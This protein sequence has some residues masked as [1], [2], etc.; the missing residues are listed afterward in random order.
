MRSGFGTLLLLLLA[1]GVLALGIWAPTG[2]TG[3]D[4]YLLGLRIPLEMMERDAWWIPF[5][6]GEPRLKKPPFIYWLG[7]ASF[8]TFGPSLA[9]GRAVTV[10]FAL[11]LLGCA[12]WLGRRLATSHAPHFTGDAEA[13]WAGLLTAGVLLGTSGIASESR[14]LMLDMP[15]AA[16][17]I[18]AFCLYW[19]WLEKPRWSA[20]LGAAALLA[21]ALL[22]KG[23]TA[24]VIFGAALLALLLARRE[25]W[26]PLLTR[27]PQQFAFAAVALALPVAWTLDVKSRHGA[28]LA[29]AAEHEL[30]ARGLW[31][32][33][34]NAAIGIVTLALPWSFVALHALWSHRH[35]AHARFLA[36]WLGLSLLPFFFIHVFD[37]YLIAS[38]LPLALACAL[39]LQAG[40]TPAWARRLGSLPPALVAIALCLLLWRWDKGG[41]WW[42]LAPVTAYFL[43][44]WWRSRAHA[45]ALIISAALLWSVGWGLAFPALGVNAVPAQVIEL[46][47]G[48]PVTLFMGPQP[49]LLPALSGR[50]LHQASRLTANDVAP[51]TLIAVRDE[52]TAALGA[53]TQALGVTPVPLFRYTALTSAGSG[54]RFARQG[55]TAED[56]K[57]AWATRSPA[58]LESTVHILEVKR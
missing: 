13:R 52:D 21:A 2:L 41:L 11:L 30:E 23:P 43:W 8:E 25:L 4:E 7:R 20:L 5:I 1:A 12:A 9:A 33:S 14:R 42:L 40:T 28:Q 15:V 50:A 45:G 35:E 16:L 55:A 24:V 6:D 38:L 29:A 32:I 36:L 17:A 19:S 27:L 48:R 10:A 53:Q 44:C 26:Q 31:N 51:G 58:P 3:K 39:A 22:T 37:R 57:A 18:A 49:A 56:W 54:I 47:R 46:S 34:P